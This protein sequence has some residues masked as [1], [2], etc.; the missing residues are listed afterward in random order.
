MHVRAAQFFCA[1]VCARSRFH[2]RRPADKDRTG[3]F[4]NHGFVRHRRNICSASCAR[5]HDD[6][7]LRNPLGAKIRL[8]VK[9]SAEV[10]TVRK[11]SRLFRQ[12]NSAGIHKIN[13]RQMILHR[14]FLRA[15]MLLDRHREIR[16]AFDGRIVCHY[17]HFASVH[18]AD[19]RHHART[20]SFVVIHSVRG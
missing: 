1:D 2:Q 19:S 15:Q 16:S 3:I 8:I 18:H 14:D 7:Y 9:N 6:R 17:E 13:A 20:G 5:A 10:I 12:K 4:D 11:C